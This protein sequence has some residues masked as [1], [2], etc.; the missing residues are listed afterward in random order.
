MA[1]SISKP[2][3]TEKF[4]DFN[5]TKWKKANTKENKLSFNNYFQETDTFC[6]NRSV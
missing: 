2:Y 5:I 1:D 4:Y 6:G 3:F